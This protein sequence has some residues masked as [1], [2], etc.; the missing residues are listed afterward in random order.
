MPLDLRLDPQRLP[1]PARTARTARDAGRAPRFVLTL[2]DGQRSDGRPRAA[3]GRPSPPTA[4]G[5]GHAPSTAAAGRAGPP[6]D[7]VPVLRAAVRHDVPAGRPVGAVVQ[8]VT[9][10]ITW[11][12]RPADDAARLVL[13]PAGTRVVG[14]VCAPAVWVAGEVVGAVTATRGALVV[15]AGGRV[16]GGLVGHGAVVVAGTVRASGLRPAIVCHGR[17]DLGCTA[18]VA[19][20]VFHQVGAVYEGPRVA[21]GVDIPSRT[22][23]SS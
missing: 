15:D 11:Y 3:V 23:S 13:I 8:A 21:G 18:R 9:A 6:P 17:L 1:E 7:A 20:E 19:A 5:H 4:H 16:T 2:P 14:D 12:E 10:P 22:M